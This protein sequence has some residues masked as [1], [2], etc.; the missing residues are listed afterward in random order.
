MR[1]YTAVILIAVLLLSLLGCAKS[2]GTAT[3]NFYYCSATPEYHKQTSVM[4]VET[5]KVDTNLS[6]LEGVLRL[7]FEGPGSQKL[8]SPFPVGTQLKTVQ[9]SK[10][11]TAVVLS[12]EI[13]TLSG[14]E[15]MIACACLAA[16]VI[17]ISQSEI[18]QIRAET[19][20]LN[21]QEFIEF[22]AQSLL[23][24]S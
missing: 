8:V 9:S 17:E 21:N 11:V 5:R 7:Y 12:D 24:F 4:Q 1:R 10:E 20:L 16:T 2:T 6:D 15:L 14:V 19:A 18:I 23:S 22:T 3:A 13:G